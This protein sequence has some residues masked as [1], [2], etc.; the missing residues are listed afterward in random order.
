MDNYTKKLILD[1]EVDT[2]YR[3]VI[4][5]RLNK[6]Y[7]LKHN[8]YNTQHDVLFYLNKKQE[9]NWD[10]KYSKLFDRIDNDIIHYNF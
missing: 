9:V 8:F 2:I 3:D 7:N 1:S 10:Y 4:V 5:Y 6:K